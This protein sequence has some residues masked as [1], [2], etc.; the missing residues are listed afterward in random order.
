MKNT[1]CALTAL[2][3]FKISFAQTTLTGTV[4]D[5]TSGTPLQGVSIKVKNTGTGTFTRPEGTYSIPVPQGA[6][7]IIS[8]VGYTEQTITT[9]GEPTINIQ[10]NS[11]SNELTQIVVVGNRGAPRSSTSSPVPVDVINVNQMKQ[12][13]GRPD[14]MS[15]LNI[16]VP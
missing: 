5:R 1:L 12:S 13:T 14:L 16:A 11:T 4:T 9:K 3:L 6:V 15:Q 8:Y 2:L 10:L 7:L